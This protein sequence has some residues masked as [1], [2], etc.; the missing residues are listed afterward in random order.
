MQVPVNLEA[1]H[2]RKN[3]VQDEEIRLAIL[4]QVDSS[5]STESNIDLVSLLG[6]EELRGLADHWVVINHQD[7]HPGRLLS[8]PP[9]SQTPCPTGRWINCTPGVHPRLH[10]PGRPH[11]TT[12][13]TDWP[14][15]CDRC[16]VA[17]SYTL[18]AHSG[19]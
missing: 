19:H 8:I 13:P 1:I 10:R 7:V 14:S 17:R 2:V 5:F 12:S 6:Q 3:Q 18:P 11:T 9:R 4:D 15:L 16:R